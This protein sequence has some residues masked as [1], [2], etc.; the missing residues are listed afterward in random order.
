MNTEE[1][2]E[3]NKTKTEREANHKRFLTTENKL[4]V[5]GGGLGG[6]MA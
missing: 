5:A 1:G 6:Q 4:R 3:K 2:K